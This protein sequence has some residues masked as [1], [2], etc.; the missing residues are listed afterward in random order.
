MSYQHF[1]WHFPREGLLGDNWQLCLVPA[2]SGLLYPVDEFAG[3]KGRAEKVVKKEGREGRTE[4]GRKRL[5]IQYTER[6]M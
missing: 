4:G 6:K 2:F 5:Q 1:K 3:L